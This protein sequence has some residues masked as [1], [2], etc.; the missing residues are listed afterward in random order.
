MLGICHGDVSYIISDDR[1]AEIFE[2]KV[3]NAI[4]MQA[5]WIGDNKPN[6]LIIDEIDGITDKEGKVTYYKYIILS[7]KGAVDILV[8]IVNGQTTKQKKKQTQQGEFKLVRPIICICNNQY[9]PVLRK[10]RSVATVYNF[11]KPRIS[12]LLDRLKVR[13]LW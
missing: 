2:S 10:L 12:R 8:K 9:V 13:H 3:L 5:N 4:E 7:F 6:C 11:E 1:S